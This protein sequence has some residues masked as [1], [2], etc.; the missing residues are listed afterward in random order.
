MFLRKKYVLLVFV[1]V[2]LVRLSGK[3]L[4]FNLPA[5]AVTVKPIC[6]K[7]QVR[8][9]E[10]NQFF[11]YIRETASENVKNIVPSPYAEL[12]LGMTIGI[13]NLKTIPRFNDVIIRAGT[14]HVV[15]VSGYNINLVFN[16]LSK[17][18]G[19]IYKFK[20]IL[21]LQITAIIY[22]LIAGFE[23]P[24]VRALI[25]CSVFIWGSFYGRRINVLYVFA[26]TAL[27]ITIY[28]PVYLF[29]V[30][31]QLSSAA[32]L[33][34][35]LYTDFLDNM[36]RN[37]SFLSFIKDAFV[38]TVSAQALTWPIIAFYFGRVSL[39]SFIA[40]PLTLWVVPIITLL[41]VP[42]VVVSYV[43]TYISTLGWYIL[44]PFTYFF[45]LV[46]ELLVGI[47]TNQFKLQLS[48][49]FMI[50]YYLCAILVSIFI[51]IVKH[52]KEN[53]SM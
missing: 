31:F 27:A 36:V 30:S 39:I 7:R 15:V 41:G 44:F 28:D 26:I 1:L 35:I 10:N 11:S 20:N 24:V 12:I 43:S 19:T 22:A 23:P 17:F 48:P 29:D 40:N 4:T 3:C 13:N 52:E 46:N 34:L 8:V 18:F 14:I 32:T 33:G 25:M 50:T 47:S 16:F 51:H 5:W 42:I 21:I 45:V 37:T 38:T 9:G 2:F 49:G 53:K 6:N